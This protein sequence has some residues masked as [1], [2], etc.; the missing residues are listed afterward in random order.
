MLSTLLR[1]KNYLHVIQTACTLNNRLSIKPAKAM[2]VKKKTPF[3]RIKLI[4][5]F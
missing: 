1:E 3:E 4:S 2:S 5:S